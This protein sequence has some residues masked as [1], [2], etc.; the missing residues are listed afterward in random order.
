MMI[1]LP[2]GKI[3][4]AGDISARPWP[5]WGCSR[6]VS[7]TLSKMSRLFVGQGF[8]CDLLEAFRGV[9]HTLAAL[10]LFVADGYRS[11]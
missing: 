10:Q 6:I 1:S 5:I 8:L 2:A 11:P 9:G 4:C 7:S 3:R